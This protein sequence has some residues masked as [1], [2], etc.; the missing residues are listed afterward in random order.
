MPVPIK[1]LPEWPSNVEAHPLL[2]IDYQLLKAGDKN[3]INRLWEAGTN[4]GFWYLK[5]H[6]AEQNFMAMW[7]MAEEMFKLPLEEKMKF[8]QGDEGL[9][10]GYKAV[11]HYIVD[12][13]GNPDPVEGVN[14]ARDDAL[15]YP[16]VSR[17]EY[18]EVLNEL[19]EPIIIPFVEKCIGLSDTMIEIFNDK[20]EL[21]KGALA[22]FHRR[23]DLCGS[24]TRSIRAPPNMNPDKL[25]IGGHTDFGTLSLLVNNLGGLQVLPP[26][27]KEWCYVRPLPGHIICNVGDTLTMFSGG[28]L[29]S[30]IHRVVVPPGLQSKYERWSQVYFARPSDDAPLLPLLESP[31]ISAHFNNLSAERQKSIS[32]GVTSSEWF[33]RRQKNYRTKNHKGAE[34]WAANRGTE[35][36]RA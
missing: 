13:A 15:S 16:K 3:E 29:N 10:F 18:P 11:G 19:M 30:N 8:E 22:K 33:T 6:G 4:L 32:P 1:E 26:G 25:A 35:N 9:S 20:L 34:T 2:V 23:E 36:G 17:R 14:V 21:P 28:I 31:I 7:G 5:N 12:A 24:E 27:T